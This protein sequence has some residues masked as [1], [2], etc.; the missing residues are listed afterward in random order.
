MKVYTSGRGRDSR[1][2][3]LKKLAGKDQW[4]KVHIDYYYGDH[5][6][7]V[8]KFIET[9]NPN[10]ML[11]RF[12]GRTIYVN[13]VDDPDCGYSDKIELNRIAPISNLWVMDVRI[14]KPV[15]IL[16]DSEVLSEIYRRNLE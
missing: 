14:K 7:K 12:S 5:Y 11:W 2:N 10:P 16:D 15:E 13:D 4:I 3:I 9:E 8:L 1:I 6:L